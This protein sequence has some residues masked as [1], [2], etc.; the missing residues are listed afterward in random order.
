MDAGKYGT[1]TTQW[2]TLSKA[3]WVM[4]VVKEIK[5]VEDLT[6]AQITEVFNKHYKQAR[7]I[8]STNVSRDLGKQKVASPPLVGETPGTPSKWYLT[9]EG[10]KTV[11]NLIIQQRNGAN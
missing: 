2:N 1:P 10:I 4:Y 5:A 9:D 8:R 6:V 11:Q 3:L 7:V